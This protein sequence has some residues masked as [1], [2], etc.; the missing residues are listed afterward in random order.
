MKLLLLLVVL[1]IPGCY[2]FNCLEDICRQ[3]GQTFER[4]D[5]EVLY[6]CGG[7]KPCAVRADVSK[8]SAL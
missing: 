3:T 2:N 1:L 5:R 8:C 6:C 4:M 7:N